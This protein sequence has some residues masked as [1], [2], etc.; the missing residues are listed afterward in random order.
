[1]DSYKAMQGCVACAIQN[2][3]RFKGTD[4]A[5]LKLYREALKEVKAYLAA[6]PRRSQARWS[7]RATRTSV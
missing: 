2:V 6:R 3:R 4:A 7:T 1:V 5:L